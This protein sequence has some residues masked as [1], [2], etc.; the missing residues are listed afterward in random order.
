MLERTKKPPIELKF[1]G[2]SENGEKA[3]NA[4]QSLGFAYISDSITMSELFEDFEEGAFLAVALLGA[5][6]KE[7]LT[8]KQLSKLTGIPQRHISE[9]EN[10]K[11]AIGA[12][13]ARMLGK[14]LSVSY[15]IFL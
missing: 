15:K 13:R 4:L 10:N 12:K 14:V 5:R 8:Q 9:I 7:N 2:P 6:T 1:I 11:R 3:I